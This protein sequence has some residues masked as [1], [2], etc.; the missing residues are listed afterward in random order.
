MFVNLI[1]IDNEVNILVEPLPK[2]GGWLL[3]HAVPIT[4]LQLT[5]STRLNALAHDIEEAYRKSIES[6]GE[7]EVLGSLTFPLK[8]SAYTAT[9]AQSYVKVESDM[10]SVLIHVTIPELANRII[11]DVGAYI[12]D[13]EIRTSILFWEH[14]YV[15]LMKMRVS[16]VLLSVED[17]LA[18]ERSFRD[19]ELRQRK[20]KDYQ[21]SCNGD[22]VLIH[23]KRASITSSI[24]YDMYEGLAFWVR[25]HVP[26]WK[27]GR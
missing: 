4:P 10:T 14:G 20:C 13:G 27:K 5:Q 25:Q 12:K 18:I 6:T 26:E 24:G 16:S 9:E 21:L 15:A 1:A 8:V 23:N 11:H 3:R 22:K 17:L 7:V 19:G 2:P